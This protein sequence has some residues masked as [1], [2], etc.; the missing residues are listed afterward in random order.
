MKNSEVE[1][2]INNQKLA[3]KK[4]ANKLKK[5]IFLSIIKEFKNFFKKLY[6]KM[7]FNLV[8][9][10]RTIIYL[11]SK[12]KEIINNKISILIPSRSRYK[13][14]ERFLDSLKL[15]TKKLYRI[16][17]LL[18]LDSDEPELQ[19]YLK[20]LDRFK[21]QINI[22]ILTNDLNTHAKRN[23]FLASHS[24]GDII[25]PAN[26]DIVIDSY[27]WD[28]EIDIQSKKFKKDSPFCIWPDSGNKYPFLHCH[29]PIINRIWY[30]KLSYVASELFNFWYLDT[31]ICDLAKRSNKFIYVKNIK[32][33]EFNAQANIDEFDETYLKNIADNKMEKDIDIWNN[34]KKIRINDAKNL[35]I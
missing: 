25:F 9:F 26:D 8:Y 4:K 28:I 21:E 11:K 18:L 16:E 31:W 17:L 13:K 6:W 34:S 7:F 3:F 20:V 22:K 30:E 27:N 5:N 12:K 2:I 35:L 33:K 19:G 23:N 10:F 15:K 32:L 14:M 24:T 29:F 1:K